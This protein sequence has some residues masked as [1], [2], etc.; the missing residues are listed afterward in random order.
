MGTTTGFSRGTQFNVAD[1]YWAIGGDEANVWSSMRAMSVPVADADYVAWLATNLHPT[2]IDTMEDLEAVFTQQFPPGS[3][4][5]YNPFARFEKL[6]GGIVVNGVP[7][8]S[9]PITRSSLNTAYIYTQSEPGATF[10]WKLP[11]GSFVTLNKAQVEE[12]QNATSAFGQACFL[13]ESDNAAA[14]DAGTITT[15]AEIDAA[16]AAVSNEFTGLA[17]DEL[18][19][20]KR[21]PRT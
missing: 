3:P 7:F 15:N 13:C 8:A 14:I 5:T 1:W 4:N 17:M 2:A 18:K 16:Y 10:D 6:N 21:K 11:D 20:R 9:D 12:I 19:V